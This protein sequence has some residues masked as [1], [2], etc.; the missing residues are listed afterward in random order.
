[1]TTRPYDLII[2]GGGPAGMTAAVYAARASLKTVILEST[3]TGGLVNSTFMVENFPSYPFIHGMELMAKMREQ[4]DAL[5]VDVEEVC[6]VESL[7]LYGVEKKVTTDDAVYTAPA[8]ILATGRCPIPLETPTEADEVHFCA[9]C[10]GAAYVDKRVL[11]VGGGNSAFDESLYMINLGVRHITLVEAM[12]HYFAAAATQEELF[13]TG[14]VVGH[15]STT[16]ADLVVQDGKVCGAVLEQTENGAQHTIPID[17]VFV[18]LGQK[19]N[20]ALFAE[21]LELTPQSYIKAGPDMGTS[22]PGVFA[23]GDIV[24]KLY[25]QITTAVADGTI[26]ALSAERFIRAQ[27][28]EK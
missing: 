16:V 9:I 26:A 25:R 3:I 18:F 27:R 10:D 21:M 5:G 2:L 11:V 8:I 6:E 4:V 17:G 7:D 15:V 28:K 13:A 22:I 1:M 19:P 24:D 20:S 14:K 23:A 12:P